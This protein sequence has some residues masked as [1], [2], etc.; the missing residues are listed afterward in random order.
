M[1]SKKKP[2]PRRCALCGA[3]ERRNW[4]MTNMARHLG[5]CADC[6]NRIIKG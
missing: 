2:E 1:K 6:I 3:P 4:F 5:I